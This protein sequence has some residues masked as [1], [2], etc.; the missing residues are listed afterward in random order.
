MHSIWLRGSQLSSNKRDVARNLSRNVWQTH[1]KAYLYDSDEEKWKLFQVEYPHLLRFVSRATFIANKPY[2]LRPAKWLT[3]MCPKCHEIK[4]F[5]RTFAK[6]A[7]LWHAEDAERGKFENT[8]PDGQEGVH[9]APHCW[10]CFQHNPLYGGEPDPLKHFPEQA[11]ALYRMSVC[12]HAANLDAQA[13]VECADGHSRRVFV[14][15]KHFFCIYRYA[16]VCVRAP[17]MPCL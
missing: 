10:K 16:C 13:T 5:A 12:A 15:F 3:C 8:A 6:A 4:D 11:E 14:L 2:W 9:P 1:N 17:V 7:P